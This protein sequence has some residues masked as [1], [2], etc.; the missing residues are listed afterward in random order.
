MSRIHDGTM[1]TAG[2]TQRLMRMKENL[3]SN[4]RSNSN[5]RIDAVVAVLLYQDSDDELSTLLIHRVQR[6]NDPWSGQIGLPGGRIEKF[7]GSTQ[8]ALEREVREEVGL[9]LSTE[10]EP[11]GVLSVGHP[12]RRI[13]MRVQPWVYV[14]KRRPEVTIGPEIQ[15]A[16]WVSL[17]KLPSLRGTSEVEIRGTRIMVEAFLVEGRVVWGFTYRVLN[18]LLAVPGTLG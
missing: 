7:D 6:S 3:S 5:E 16:F 11:L 4:P 17:L 1:P 15:Q 8:K 2:L 18:E 14:L 10:G 13:E 9:E 12:G